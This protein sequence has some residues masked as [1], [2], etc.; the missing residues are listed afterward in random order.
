M[1]DRI[2][3]DAWSFGKEVEYIDA[4]KEDIK[5]LGFDW[6]EREYY[7]SDYFEKIYANSFFPDTGNNL[8][9]LT[10]DDAGKADIFDVNGHSLSSFTIPT[11]NRYSS[12]VITD[13]DNDGYG[14]VS[15]VACD[16]RWRI[17]ELD[18]SWRKVL[19]SV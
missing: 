14:L 9:I 6:Q 1:R 13:I 12:F 18:S 4:I 3:I 7:A 2:I 11:G 5:W 16:F 8:Q 19:L 17:V 10:V 15:V